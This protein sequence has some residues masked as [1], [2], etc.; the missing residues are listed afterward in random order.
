MN[1]SLTDGQQP[2]RIGV[3]VRTFGLAGALRCRLDQEAVPGIQAPS[4][5][6]VGF[7]ASFARKLTLL[8]C[9]MHDRDLICHFD[10]VTDQTA[11]QELVDQALFLP[12]VAL[13]YDSPYADPN[14]IGCAVVGEDGR[15]LG[16][17]ETI[18][19]TRAHYVWVIRSGDREWMLPA[20]PEFVI[21]LRNDL[22]RV[23]VRLI[24]GMIEEVEGN[25]QE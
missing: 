23:V 17:I 25:G 4:P 18:G 19:A 14:L 20:I 5:C 7:S 8:R 12:S 9:E 13:S 21:E 24:P 10:G 15:E 2:V 6:L 22:R 1:S 11:A 16:V 3:L